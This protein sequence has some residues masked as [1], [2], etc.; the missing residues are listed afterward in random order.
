MTGIKNEIQD[1]FRKYKISFNNLGS[2]NGELF[3]LLDGLKHCENFER[4]DAVLILN[5]VCFGI[6]HFEVSI[7]NKDKNGD[8]NRK[9]EGRKPIEINLGKIW[10]LNWGLI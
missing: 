7:Y 6:E 9:A 4:P 8:T 10:Y 3:A 1:I 2:N 5:S